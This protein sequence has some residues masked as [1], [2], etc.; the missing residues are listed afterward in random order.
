VTARV[1]SPSKIANPAHM[2]IV[3]S[4]KATRWLDWKQAGI[5]CFLR[6]FNNYVV[7]HNEPWD[8]LE[9]FEPIAFRS[10]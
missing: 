2:G 7:L 4:I 3:P 1:A 10:W 6:T 8:L 9:A 5:A